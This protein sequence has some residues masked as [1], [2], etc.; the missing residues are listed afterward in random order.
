MSLNET[1]SAERLHIAFLGRR[2]V[3][4][5]SLVNA[6]TGQKLSVVSPV[7]GTTTDPVKKAMELLPLGPVVIIDT[8]GYDDEGELGALRVEK[9]KEI[10]DKTDVAV[11]VYDAS[12]GLSDEDRDLLEKLKARKLPVIL[13]ANKFDLASVGAA[14]GRPPEGEARTFSQ[15]DKAAGNRQQATGDE[16]ERIA[17]TSVHTGRAMTESKAGAAVEDAVSVSALTG[18]GVLELKERLAA[19][20]RTAKAPKYILADLVSPGDTVILVIPID[21]SA[22]KGRLILPQQQ[23]LRELLDLHCVPICCQVEEIPAVL[24]GLKKP[25]R[26][27]VTDSQAFGRVSP[28]VPSAIPLT[29]FSILFARYKGELRQLV[30]GARA[31]TALHDGDRV[32]I[33]EGCTHHRQCNDI[34]SVKIPGWV[35]N[36]IGKELYFVFTSGGEFPE[37]LSGYDLVIHCGGCMLNEA[38]MKHRME[39][40]KRCGVPMVNYGVAIAQIHGILARSLEPFSD[41]LNR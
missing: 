14:I 24:E 3:G 9:T 41:E 38:A 22:P 11:L 20:G 28:L 1:V 36:Y 35:R 26:L 21:E 10:L 13:A 25:P 7:M 33:S 16:R 31:L 32:L 17:A 12:V 6:V 8:P 18:E 5:S 40:A 37:D 23:S 15:P 39:V 34:G 27:V 2:N 30:E 19:L 4:K 29:S